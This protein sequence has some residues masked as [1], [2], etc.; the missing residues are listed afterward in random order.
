MSPGT[1][2]F[3]FYRGIFCVAAILNFSHDLPEDSFLLAVGKP[4]ENLTHQWLIT[5]DV[6]LRDH[7]EVIN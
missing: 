4:C 7:L 1:L 3:G 6:Q 5:D 2:F